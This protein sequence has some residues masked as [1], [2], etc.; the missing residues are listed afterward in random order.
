[1]SNF[2]KKKT[3]TDRI[4]TMMFEKNSDAIE[5]ISTFLT[6]QQRLDRHHH[7]IDYFS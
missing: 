7:G 3:A 4:F 2:D 5:M 6:L 1:M